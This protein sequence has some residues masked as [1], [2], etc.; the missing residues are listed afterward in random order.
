V[1]HHN[2]LSEWFAISSLSPFAVPILVLWVGLQKSTYI[3][4]LG[5]EIYL[6]KVHI[7]GT[8]A[9]D[10][11][12]PTLE[13]NKHDENFKKQTKFLILFSTCK[14]PFVG[15]LIFKKKMPNKIALNH[16]FSI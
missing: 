5:C 10:D 12:A 6:P 7:L 11:D 2:D 13:R 14:L 3:T 9:V 16:Y 8:A 4:K 15:V 1:A